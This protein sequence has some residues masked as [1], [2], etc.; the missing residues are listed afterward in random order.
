MML[1]QPHEPK[2][3]EIK[4]MTFEDYENLLLTRRLTPHRINFL[5]RY[6]W[7]NDFMRRTIIIKN[8]P[9]GI[10]AQCILS[11]I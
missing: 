11:K 7:Q 6:T 5:P 9:P 4:K 8:F 10:E 3:G 2:K 1:S